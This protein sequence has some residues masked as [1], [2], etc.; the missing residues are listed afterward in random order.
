MLSEAV[1]GSDLAANQLV[2]EAPKGLGGMA[3]SNRVQRA[4]AIRMHK[5]AAA[6]PRCPRTWPPLPG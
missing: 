1:A 3:K 6:T 2:L 4:V 5:T